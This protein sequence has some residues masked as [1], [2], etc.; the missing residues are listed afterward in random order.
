MKTQFTFLLALFLA[1]STQSVLAQTVDEYVEQAEAACDKDNYKAAIKIIDEAKAKG[2]HDPRLYFIEGNTHEELENY[3]EAFDAY[4]DGISTFPEDYKLLVSRGIFYLRMNKVDF[5]IADY[6]KAMKVAD[7]DTTFHSILMN[8]AMAKQRKRDFAGAYEDM[9]RVYQF[10]STN[11]AVVQNLGAICDEAG[12]GDQTLY[13]LHKAL[14]LDP[15]FYQININIGFKYQ[16]MG[17]YAKANEYF[18]KVLE[19]DPKQALAYSN[20]SYNKLQLDDLRGAMKDIEKSLKLYP[21]NSY[22]YRIKA[23]ILL[24]M[25]KPA[26]ACVEIEQ[27][28]ELGFTQQYGD[29]V[30]KLKAE[31]CQ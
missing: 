23:L 1:F 18:D 20:R 21:G 25:K 4:N 26:E 31:H 7:D 15:T 11:A 12:H 10:D 29:E 5:A 22:A 30:K 28:L 16:E 2:I 17:E 19:I 9:V 13:Y 14:E 27:A 24:E 3:Q 6:N 8:R